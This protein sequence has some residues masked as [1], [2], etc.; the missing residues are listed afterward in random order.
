MGSPCSALNDDS[1]A[2]LVDALFYGYNATVLA[3]GQTGSG[4]MY[5]MGTN[6]TGEESNGGIKPKAMESIIRRVEAMKDSTKVFIKIFEDKVFDLLDPYSSV[7][8]KAKGASFAK[9]TTH[10][11]VPIQIRETFLTSVYDSFHHFFSQSHA[12]FT[13]TMEQNKISHCLAGA[14]NDD[15]GDDILHAKLHLVDLAGFIRAK[16]SGADGMRFKEGIHINKD[17]LALGNVISASG[18]KKKRKEGG[19]V[20][21]R[22]SKLTCLLQDS[23][24]RSSKTILIACV[25][26]ADTNVEETI[27]TLKYAQIVLITGRARQFVYNLLTRYLLYA[28]AENG[29][30][31]GIQGR[32]AGNDQEPYTWRPLPNKEKYELVED[33]VDDDD[34]KS[35][36]RDLRKCVVQRLK[37]HDTLVRLNLLRISKK[38]NS[39]TM[40]K[41]V[42]LINVEAE[43]L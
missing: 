39:P 10:A 31:P 34:D 43:L 12:I 27:N 33:C 26:P 42:V 3:Y 9:P 13:I 32:V 4:K 28:G 23:L 2:P 19:H 16:R 20:P 40:L 24:G 11:R 22:D 7:F 36:T 18:D 30:G 29:N 17:L 21:Y 14:K 41:Q 35:G 15:L 8:F 1:V 37:S 38:H 6:Y 25:N 5:T